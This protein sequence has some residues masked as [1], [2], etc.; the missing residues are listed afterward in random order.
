MIIGKLTFDSTPLLLAPMEDVTDISFRWICK[1]FG[2]DLMYTEFVPS[3]SIIRNIERSFKKFEIIEDERPIGIQLYGHS[4]AAMTEAAKIAAE[5][6]PDLI[7]LNFG[8]P[9]RKIA[10]RGA[11]AGMLKDIPKMIAMT[12]AVVKAVNLPVTA[13]TRLGWDDDSKNIVEIAEQLQDVGIAA[14]TIHGRTRAQMYSGQADWTLIGAVKNNPRMHIP[15]IGNGD[16]DSGPKAKRMIERY[17]V[18]GIM[19][20]RAT[21]GRPWIFQEIKHYLTTGSEAPA[22]SVAQKTELAR[23]HLQKSL[24]YKGE[25][26]GIREMRR[27]LATYFKSLPNFRAYRQ[28]LVTCNEADEIRKTLDEIE[29]RYGAMPD[30]CSDNVWS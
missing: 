25:I 20:G 9:V 30:S 11:G 16:I 29:T 28:R 5:W 4:I 12:E 22:L 7:D 8:C 15:I 14:L 21:V 13:K 1:H 3:E 23:L 27:H 10:T 17:G 18:D 24:E 26:R 19:I 6:N 2:A